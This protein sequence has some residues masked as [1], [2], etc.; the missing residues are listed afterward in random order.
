VLGGRLLLIALE[1]EHGPGQVR[2]G[3]EVAAGLQ[4]LA[5][6]HRGKAQRL[7][8]LRRSGAADEGIELQTHVLEHSPARIEPVDAGGGEQPGLHQL[9][10]VGHLLGTAGAKLGH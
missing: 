10:Q 7:G 2:E 5:R 6:H 1:G 3:A 4:L 8:R 9:V